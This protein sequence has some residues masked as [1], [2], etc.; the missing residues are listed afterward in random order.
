MKNNYSYIGDVFIVLEVDSKHKNVMNVFSNQYA[1][2]NCAFKLNEAAKEAK[3]PQR[4]AVICRSLY[5]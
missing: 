1:A 4:F 2:D 3:L 5:E